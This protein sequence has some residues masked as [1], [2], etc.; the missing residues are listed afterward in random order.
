M[1]R[2]CVSCFFRPS[3][4]IK[5][6][7]G[8]ILTR[9]L[10]VLV[11]ALAISAP[12]RSQQIT[13]KLSAFI[14]DQAPTFAQVIKPWAEAINA[15]GAGILKIDLFPGG[16]L[17]GNPGLQPKMVTDGVADIALVIPAYSPGR[18]PDNEVMELPNIVRNSTESSVA[19]SRLYDRGLLRGYD[20]FHVIMLSTTNPYA[21]HTK[22][23]VKTMAD[24]SGRKLRAGGPVASAAMRALGAV[25]VGMPI[26]EVAENISRGVIDGTGGDW[27]V[28][29]SFRIIETA[30]NH[31]M[32]TLGTV[33]VAILMNREV[34]EGLPDAARALIDK[35][36]GEALSRRFGG[37]HDGIQASK[38]A[39]TKSDPVQTIVLPSQAE[40]AEWDAT[41][42]P[43]IDTWVRGHPNGAALFAALEEEL[44][45]IRAGR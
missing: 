34:Y 13:L 43:V 9:I 4:S 44:A 16:A 7:E 27:D 11:A 40:L 28:M 2:S 36:S 39:E 38:L 12:A 19:I 29:Y 37:V 1:E 32:A 24:I 20:D 25:P 33:P 6:G 41:M 8:D 22:E 5:D 15:E 45:N 17:G 3:G 26:T 42:A 14:P 10:S 31:Y 23:P 21:I 35:H 30:K 18:F